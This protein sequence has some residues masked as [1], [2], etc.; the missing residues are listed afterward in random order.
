MRKILIGFVVVVVI[1]IAVHFR[2][3][4]AKPPRETAYAANRE[5]TR[6]EHH[7]T[8]ALGRRDRRTLAIRSA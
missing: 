4:R 7:R 5:V 3:H 2:F 1:A 8:G 6:L